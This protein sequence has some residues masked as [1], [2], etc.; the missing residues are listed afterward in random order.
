MGVW[1]VGVRVMKGRVMKGRV[2]RVRVGLTQAAAIAWQR[3]GRGCEVD[4]WCMV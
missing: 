2:M 4:V 3:E 1:V